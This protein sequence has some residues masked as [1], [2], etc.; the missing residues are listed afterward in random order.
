MYMYETH[1]Y[2][3]FLDSYVGIYIFIYV[4]MYMCI[5]TSSRIC[6]KVYVQLGNEWH[7]SSSL[8]PPF[9]PFPTLRNVMCSSVTSV[10][11]NVCS[12]VC[13]HNIYIYIYIILQSNKQRCYF[14]N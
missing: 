13:I 5:R 9:F 7:V 6:T 3:I 2:N 8:F 10:Y 14:I 1:V 11:A 12:S 4:Y